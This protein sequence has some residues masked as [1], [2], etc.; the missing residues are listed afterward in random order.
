MK[1]AN[2]KNIFLAIIIL[3]SVSAKAQWGTSRLTS[4]VKA[5]KLS[6]GAYQGMT[7]ILAS[8]N[9]ELKIKVA[10]LQMENSLYRA[11]IDTL[12]SQT[13]LYDEG[14]TVVD[15]K[16]NI[17][18]YSEVLTLIKRVRDLELI[19]LRPVQSST[20]KGVIQFNN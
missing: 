7:K 4:E 11:R 13:V 20:A 9:V 16:I 15:G 17:T 14:F 6:F 5:M 18:Q 19:K 3:T 10:N 2:M 8:E 1:K 12:E